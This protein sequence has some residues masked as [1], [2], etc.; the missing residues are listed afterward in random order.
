MNNSN[1]I[2]NMYVWNSRSEVC[3]EPLGISS[4]QKQNRGE[5]KSF[6]P[7]KFMYNY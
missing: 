5:N 2:E 3:F 6:C 4:E 7:P 1:V